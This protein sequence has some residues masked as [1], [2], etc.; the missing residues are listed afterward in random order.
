[1]LLYY[2]DFDSFIN[3]ESLIGTAFNKW[4]LFYAEETPF[5]TKVIDRN[6]WALLQTD[7]P[8]KTSVLTSNDP[9]LSSVANLFFRIKTFAARGDFNF[10][11]VLRYGNSGGIA[12]YHN[13]TEMRL[14]SFTTADP[15]ASPTILANLDA[16][17]SHI[18]DS[19]WISANGSAIKIYLNGE[20]INS[21]TTTVL[22]AG[23]V[24]LIA[25]NGDW[26]IDDVAVENFLDDLL[27]PSGLTATALSATSAR[28]DWV[29]N[30]PDAGEI[31]IEKKVATGAWI[32]IDKAE[33]TAVSYIDKHVDSN[34]LNTY[35]IRAA[36]NP[37]IP[38]SYWL[39]HLV[40]TTGEYIST[41]YSSSCDFIYGPLTS[42][43]QATQTAV[44]DC[45]IQTPEVVF[46]NI[47]RRAQVKI[48]AF[49]GLWFAIALRNTSTY[50]LLYLYTDQ[51]QPGTY[52]VDFAKLLHEAGQDWRGD[53]IAI[54]IW[55]D[56]SITLDL[57]EIYNPGL[58]NNEDT[59]YFQ[60]FF[61]DDDGTPISDHPPDINRVGTKFVDLSGGS[62]V[63]ESDK[64]TCLYPPDDGSLSV[65]VMVRS[66]KQSIII[67]IDNIA[68]FSYKF[69]VDID[70]I[71][72]ISPDGLWLMHT[73]AV[74]LLHDPNWVPTL[75]E[76]TV[77]IEVHPFFISLII[78][79]TVL[80][81]YN[82]GT[83]DTI[84]GIGTDSSA[85]PV[86]SNILFNQ[87]KD[88]SAY[89]AEATLTITTLTIQEI[90]ERY[91]EITFDRGIYVKR[92]NDAG[93]YETEWQNINDLIPFETRMY[94]VCAG[95][96]YA[97]PNNTYSLG[98][99]TIDNA[100]L[101][102]A[103][104]NGQWSNE[105]APYSIFHG[106]I[107]HKSLI[108]IV[109]SFIDSY[110]YPGSFGKVSN[111]TFEGFIDDR[112]CV[113]NSN[114]TENI[115]ATD[116]LGTLLKTITLADMT[117][118][119]DATIQ[120]LVYAVMNRALF[121]AFFTV[122]LINIVPGFNST[123]IDLTQYDQSTTAFDLLQDLSI[124][125]SI[126]YVKNGVF[127][128]KSSDPS[129]TVALNLWESPQRKI[130]FDK[131]N[132]GG[133]AVFDKLYWQDG[134]EVY[135]AATVAYGQTYAF[136]IAGINHPTQRQG[137][138]NYA[139][140]R[141][142]QRKITF[143]LTI[144]F[145]PILFLLDRISILHRGT[146]QEGCFILDISRLDEG[147]FLDPIGAFGIASTE[148]WKITKLS[149]SSNNQTV[150]TLEQII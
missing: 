150:M 128:Y 88:Y 116:I 46:S 56:G 87:Y 71:F 147:Y 38:E 29:N 137:L 26:A 140:P 84:F 79:T 65:D 135:T 57:A 107:R 76:H 149:H 12:F 86:L 43:A 132:S 61:E 18:Q 102:F 7:D 22:G 99:V 141:L 104:Q 45:F 36:S 97:L 121:T 77:Y 103:N 8:T 126:F 53:G 123:D 110:S 60:D 37:A 118:P 59:C 58:Y 62:W 21:T 24:G 143:E 51:N 5:F 68:D 35:R 80:K 73:D 119:A 112:L 4:S 78:G 122:S 101:M 34:L 42:Q 136:S 111:I 63:I 47:Y 69:T 54:E 130:K 9:N 142:C 74:I 28:L 131:Y 11:I 67:R 144:P 44:E 1:M 13:L 27:A 41:W 124:G 2:N 72:K 33:G 98:A 108:R 125:H 85:L 15:F 20:L 49:T 17:A 75:G 133:N 95:I 146:L 139:G 105:D 50:E 114:D 55:F 66:F 100:S 96:Q 109:D 6:N 120:N 93:V 39:D 148:N 117:L 70:K 31:L 113:T 138:L 90:W 40:G 134:V 129:A 115:I 91:S 92:I 48:D 94:Q 89:S 145:L 10:G 16:F 23:K 83:P 106:Y 52:D 32:Q 81:Y 19:I 30:I 25:Y 64:L 127:Y 82:T 3:G 14:I